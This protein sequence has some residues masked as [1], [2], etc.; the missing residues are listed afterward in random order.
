MFLVPRQRIEMA[1]GDA[2]AFG[3]ADGQ[4]VTVSA[5]GSAVDAT[6]ALRHSVPAGSAFLQDGLESDSANEL[7][8]PLVDVQPVRTPAGVAA[9]NGGAEVAG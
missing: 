5:D 3:V 8:G 1:P 9:T 4:H 6:V 2:Q 7:T